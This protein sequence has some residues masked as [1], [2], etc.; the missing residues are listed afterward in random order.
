MVPLS[1]LTVNEDAHISHMQKQAQHHI[2]LRCCACFITIR[3][4]ERHVKLTV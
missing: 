1:F 4:T 2:S 3:N